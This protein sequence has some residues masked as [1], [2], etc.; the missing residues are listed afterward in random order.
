MLSAILALFISA[1]ASALYTEVG[2]NY[3]YKKTFIDEMNNSEQQG[4]TGSVSFYF[5][6]RVAVE[7]SYT[8]SVYSKRERND[9]STND[10][11]TTTQYAEIYGTDL[12]YVFADKKA[13]FQPYM[14]GGV[15]YIKKRQ[16][17]DVDNQ[18]QAHN[19]ITIKP[20]WAPSYGVGFKFFLTEAF[21]IRAGWDVVRTPIDDTNYADDLS[22]RVGL[23]WIF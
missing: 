8:S 6:E 4:T 23:S 11:R 2:I 15:A 14:K 19:E 17:T 21:A 3:M 22:G 13:K 12:I 16:T 18:P 5:W 9:A 1:P 7:L 10:K 20:G